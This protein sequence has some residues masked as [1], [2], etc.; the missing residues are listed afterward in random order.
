MTV[1]TAVVIIVTALPVTVNTGS[2]HNEPC[3]ASRILAHLISQGP[4]SVDAYAI[5]SSPFDR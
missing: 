4:Y 3:T 1:T 2:M 5:L